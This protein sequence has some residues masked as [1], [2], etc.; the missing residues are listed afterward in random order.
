MTGNESK[1]QHACGASSAARG[2]EPES[3]GSHPTGFDC[4]ASPVGG[5]TAGCPCGFIMRRHRFVM[6]AMLAVMGLAMLVI[7]SGAVLGIIG[8]LRTI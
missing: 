1:T 6:F 3:T 8:F 7:C 5:A 2:S 4:F